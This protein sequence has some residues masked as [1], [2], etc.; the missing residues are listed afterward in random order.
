MIMIVVSAPTLHV[1]IAADV[2]PD[3]ATIEILKPQNRQTGIER[4]KRRPI[5]A[6][7]HRGALAFGNSH[8]FVRNYPVIGQKNRG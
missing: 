6:T 7:S 1:G 8:G 5:D 4:N 3:F 2:G